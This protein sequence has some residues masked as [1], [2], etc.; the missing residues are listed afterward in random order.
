M[1]FHT[2]T[3]VPQPKMADGVTAKATAKL[4]GLL[5]DFSCH[6]PSAP[7]VRGCLTSQFGD[8]QDFW[9]P[10]PDR[11]HVI[12]DITGKFLHSSSS[13]PASTQLG[14]WLETK[15]RTEGFHMCCSQDA[16]ITWLLSV[17]RKLPGRTLNLCHPVLASGGSC[18]P[19]TA[20]AFPVQLAI[21]VVLLEFSINWGFAEI[22]K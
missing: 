19:E 7:P 21:P 20:W 16:S 11:A 4:S 18:A 1:P 17:V 13:A 12:A 5:P 14:F 15:K 2:S 3:L 6:L 8:T 10:G 22:C 9:G